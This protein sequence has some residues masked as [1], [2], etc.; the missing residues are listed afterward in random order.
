MNFENLLKRIMDSNVN[1]R[2]SLV[3]DNDGNIL[4]TGHRDGVTNF[5]SAEE[6]ATSLKRA[7]EAWKGRKELSQKQLVSFIEKLN[8]IRNQYQSS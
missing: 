7:A 8:F 6:T 4:A 5:L 1:I 3:T 2:H